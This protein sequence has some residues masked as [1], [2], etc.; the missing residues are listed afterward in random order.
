MDLLTRSTEILDFWF[1]HEEYWFN[2][3]SSDAII[4]SKFHDYLKYY[5]F[6][7][8]E[9]D[10]R[11]HLAKIILYDQLT[12]HFYRDD[13]TKYSYN[14]ATCRMVYFGICNNY[15]LS[16]TPAQRCFFLMPL[17]HSKQFYNLKIAY[18]KITDYINN[19]PC[20]QYNRFFYQTVKELSVY[21][22]ITAF[23]IN[24][25]QPNMIPDSILYASIIDRHNKEYMTLFNP[26]KSIYNFNR[27]ELGTSASYKAIRDFIKKNNMKKVAVSLSGGVDSMILLTSMILLHERE[28]L[29]QVHAIHIN[30][31]NRWKSVLEREFVL[32][33]CLYHKVPIIIRDITEIH[34]T[35]EMREIYEN[36]TREIRFNMYRLMN[37]P[38]FLGHNQDDCLENMIT[39]IRRQ[40]HFDNLYGM[41][42]MATISDVTICRP[43]LKITKDQIMKTATNINLYHTQNSTPVW[44]DRWNIR[45]VFLAFTQKHQPGF[46]DGLEH[47][48]SLLQDSYKVINLIVD[49]MMARTVYDEITG[50]ITAP[51]YGGNEIFAIDVW[52][53]FFQQLSIKYNFTVV[54]KRSIRHF[55][56]SNDYNL[57]SQ[58]K[59]RQYQL[60]KQITCQVSKDTVCIKVIKNV[61]N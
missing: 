16:Y 18:D 53:L 43:L 9:S 7:T 45:N 54:S 1:S 35:S 59:S 5:N 30:Y 28:E 26:F 58:D 20:S 44:S 60:S 19:D 31:N 6:R 32:R 52:F 17:R 61:E 24:V 12:R 42:D 8:D 15:D 38:V 10:P 49:N 51:Y 14:E 27:I 37:M 50:N 47:I 4:T 46:N 3:P 23:N 40:Q 13:P 55:V 48:T 41:E 11:I 39:N 29:D 34:R 2:N 56:S 36:V 33:F 22:D 25:Y 21:N 57:T